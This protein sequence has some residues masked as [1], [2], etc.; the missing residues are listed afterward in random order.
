MRKSMSAV[1]LIV[2]LSGPG[3]LALPSPGRAQAPKSALTIVK[4]TVPELDLYDD[5]G[6]G[7]GTLKA[8]NL[9]L[10][11]PVYDEAPAG[12]VKIRLVDGSLVW[13][14]KS[15]VTIRSSEEVAPCDPGRGM[16]AGATRGS[17]ARCK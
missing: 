14:N 11:L 4:I 1:S 5:K 15:Q 9:I 13:I 3:L 10:P 7:I 2:I 8:S 12:R 6:K 16:V 17:G